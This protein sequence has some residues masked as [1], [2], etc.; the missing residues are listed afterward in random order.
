[1]DKIYSRKRIKLP[2]IKLMYSK[3]Q[4]NKNLSKITKIFTVLIIAFMFVHLAIDAIYPLLDTLCEKEAESIATLISN[5]QATIVMKNYKY[6]DIMK[7]EKDTEGSIKMI[8]AN[9]I[10]I[11][12]IISDVAIK[13]QEELNKEEKMKIGIRLGTFTGSRLLSGRGPLVKIVIIPVG[14]VETDLRSEFVSEG[15]NQ[16]LHRVYL[17]VNCKVNIL[18]PF[19]S[20][21]KEIRN[22]VLLMENVIV[23]N[24][25]NSYYNFERCTTRRRTRNHGVKINCFL[26]SNMICF[27]SR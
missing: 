26:Y 10:T 17:Q 15:V 1:M 25:P 27:M 21:Q 7:I 18:T 8:S 11:N 5:E 12:E 6:E 14:T 4:N 3:N 13:I 16:T 22:Q 23:G 24:I 9:M 2:Q 20:I 19:N